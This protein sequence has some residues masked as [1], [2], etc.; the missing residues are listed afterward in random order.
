MLSDPIEI[1]QASVDYDFVRTGMSANGA[2]YQTAD[3]LL[4]L[5]IAHQRSGKGSQSRLRHEIRLD[6]DEVGADP[7]VGD[8]SHK[9]TGSVYLVV[10]VPD[11]GSSISAADAVNQVDKVAKILGSASSWDKLLRVVQ[12]ES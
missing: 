6:F 5:T 2:Q 4:R 7:F 10:N 8:L 3:G 9:Y 11:T 1:T 12:G